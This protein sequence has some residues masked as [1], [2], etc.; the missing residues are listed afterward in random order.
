MALRCRHNSIV[1]KDSAKLLLE[2]ES[3]KRHG[4]FL[5]YTSSEEFQ[6]ALFCMFAHRGIMRPEQI[7]LIFKK[8]E[9][10]ILL[11]H[12][13]FRNSNFY[14]KN[15]RFHYGNDLLKNLN[16]RD[17]ANN[18]PDY[19]KQYYVKRG[20][21][22][23]VKPNSDGTSYDPSQQ[24]IDINTEW[25]RIHDEIT[26]LNGIFD[27]VWINDFSGDLGDFDYQVLTPNNQPKKYNVTFN[28][29]GELIKRVNYK[30]DGFD[31]RMS[32]SSS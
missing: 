26:Y 5:Y 2:N 25:E 19:V 4:L 23:Y 9:T 30:P 3:N 27:L 20:D 12:M 8:H 15:G 29:T 10:K 16:L 14:V 24:P 18:D 28:G 11:F 32:T 13:I 6:K 31:D 7:G 21:C 1:L 22:I 17:L